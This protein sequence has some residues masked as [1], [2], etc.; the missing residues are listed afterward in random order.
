MAST[1]KT[2]EGNI[3]DLSTPADTIV[4]PTNVGWKSSDGKNPMGKGL[5]FQ[6]SKRF[7]FLPKLYGDF[8]KK[9]KNLTPILPIRVPRWCHILLLVPTKELNEDKPYLSWHGNT[10][11]DA[12]VTR[13]KQL[14]HFAQSFVITGETYPYYTPDRRILVPALGSG[15]GG[16]PKGL[17]ETLLTSFL[18]HPSFIF[19]KYQQESMT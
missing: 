8:C 13:L 15:H 11:A 3:W 17:V 9:Y 19:V 7:R 12:L 4:I 14:Q 5:A 1:V 10:S 6:A 18:T 2:L 16:L